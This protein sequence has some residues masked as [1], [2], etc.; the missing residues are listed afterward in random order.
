[1]VSKNQGPQVSGAALPQ[2]AALLAVPAVPVAALARHPAVQHLVGQRDAKGNR[3][4]T[5]CPGTCVK[6]H[7]ARHDVGHEA[8]CCKARHEALSCHHHTMSWSCIKAC[9]PHLAAAATA[10]QLGARGLATHSTQPA[11]GSSRHSVSRAG[12][13]RCIARHTAAAAA[14]AARHGMPATSAWR[15]PHAHF[16]RC[17]GL[18][19][20]HLRHRILHRTNAACRHIDK[21][22]WHD[23]R[24]RHVACAWLASEATAHC[25]QLGTQGRVCNHAPQLQLA[26]MD[27]VRWSGAENGS[28]SC[29]IGL[30][31]PFP[32][33]SANMRPRGIEW[34]AAEQLPHRRQAVSQ[35]Y[36]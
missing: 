21:H 20:R 29:P 35:S 12:M 31:S 8:P 15:C 4:C 7:A 6:R 30:A 24:C 9:D 32:A 34:Q 19:G 22:A 26:S 5:S 10:L 2:E 27:G 28:A 1:M 16:R 18:S 13:R 33:G 11:R 23:L 36:V 25:I 3:Q 14:R 17:R